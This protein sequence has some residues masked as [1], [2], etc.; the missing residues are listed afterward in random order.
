MTWSWRPCPVELAWQESHPEG[1]ASGVAGSHGPAVGEAQ[2]GQASGGQCQGG[3]AQGT[4]PGQGRG[5]GSI[6][7]PGC[8]ASQGS[9]VG[10][11]RVEDAGRVQEQDPVLRLCLR[12]ASLLGLSSIHTWSGWTWLPILTWSLQQHLPSVL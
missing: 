4:W 6:K 8:F 5:Q 11:Q 7:G 1:Q 3:T 2:G 10:W 9:I 12:P